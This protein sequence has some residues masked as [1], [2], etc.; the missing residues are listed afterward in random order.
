VN[1]PTLPES[2]WRRWHDDE[3][4][5]LGVSSCL[6]GTSVRYDG[7][8][9]HDPYLTDVLGEF[10][11][12]VPVCPEFEIGLGVPRPTIQLENGDPHPQLIEPISGE[13]LTGR[14]ESYARKRL[15]EI[16]EFGMDGFILKS[17]SPSC[18][19]EGVKVFRHDEPPA[20]NGIGIFARVL[21]KR[22]P[23]FPVAEEVWFSDPDR[24]KEFLERVLEQHRERTEERRGLDPTQISELETVHRALLGEL[25]V[26]S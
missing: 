21:M 8:H 14:M 3:P 26:K 9:K 18:G 19:V 13:V 24:R 1:R 11:E 5:R 6:L 20:R 2:S 10:L 22:W 7:G 12:W 23:D 15:T 16:E 4:I 17:R 25:R